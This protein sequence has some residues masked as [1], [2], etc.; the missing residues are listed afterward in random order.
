MHRLRGFLGNVANNPMT[1]NNIE[2]GAGTVTE[3]LFT[4]IMLT[5][6]PLTSTKSANA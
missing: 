3:A 1:I 2:E 4:S 6:S 5:T